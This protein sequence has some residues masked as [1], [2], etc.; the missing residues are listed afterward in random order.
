M[1]RQTVGKRALDSA[2]LDSL[3]NT[4][5]GRMGV[6]TDGADSGSVVYSLG[7]SEQLTFPPSASLSSFRK[8]R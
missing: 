5:L 3:C 2:E 4:G 8:W 7:D 6:E 1:K